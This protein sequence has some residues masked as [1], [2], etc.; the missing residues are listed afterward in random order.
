M[1]RL[2][3]LDPTSPK[4]KA[5]LQEEF[6]RELFDIIREDAFGFEWTKR[7]KKEVLPFDETKYD[8]FIKKN[9]LA[10]YQKLILKLH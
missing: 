8:R 4:F 10:I 5:A 9:F 3:G 7:G 6:E 1:L 2:K